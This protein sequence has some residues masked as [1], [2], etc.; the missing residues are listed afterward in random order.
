M[1]GLGLETAQV[2]QHVGPGAA[3]ELLAAAR[4]REDGR[5]VGHEDLQRAYPDLHI[6]V[7][8]VI[9]EGDKA[10]GR[11]TV[12]ETHQ[13]EYMGLPPTG[14]SVT[15]NEIFI[16]RLAGGRIVETL[17]SRRRLL[18]DATARRDSRRRRLTAGPGHL[19]G[20]HGG[21][22]RHADA[23]GIP[24]R[25]GALFPGPRL[26]VPCRDVAAS[27][28]P[29]KTIGWRAGKVVPWQAQ[30]RSSNQQTRPR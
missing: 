15:Y 9:A 12:T 29:F 25:R 10:V 26:C 4:C 3:P 30:S 24:D 5:D 19:L 18:A 28:R 23:L 22:C 21:S 7:E 2:L 13:G 6:T 11:N 17:G 14:K 1:A 20:R 8:D 27:A 16:F